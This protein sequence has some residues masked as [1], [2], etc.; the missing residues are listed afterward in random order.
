LGLAI[1]R[2][3]VELHGG[4][5]SADSPGEGEGAT[6]TLELPIAADTQSPSR[7]RG[8]GN[9]RPME[10]LDQ[11]HFPL[12]ALN[13]IRVLLVDDDQ[14]NLQL[15]TLLL[16]RQR[17]QVHSAASA[18]EA[19]EVLRW[20][21]PDV[22][23]LD[24]AMPDE[25][26]YSLIGRVRALERETGRHTP[27]IALT[28]YVRVEDRTRALSAGFNMF[29]PKPINAQELLAAIACLSDVTSTHRD[30]SHRTL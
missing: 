26:G 20:Y 27:A 28:A 17:A 14:D 5:I 1:A 23:V 13:N 6:F 25:D 16:R 2:H 24:L 3:L 19:L 15:L 10:T 7:R 18:A 22:M 29:V 4:V 9:L 12:P 11:E 8:T 30:A 21:E